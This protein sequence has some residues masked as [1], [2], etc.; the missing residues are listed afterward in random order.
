[1]DVRRLIIS[2]L[3]IL[4][5]SSAAK[6]EELSQCLGSITTHEHR[7]EKEEAIRL[8]FNKFKSVISQENCFIY[9]AKKVPRLASTK[10][11]EDIKSICFYETTSAKD[12]GSCMNNTKKFKSSSDHDEAVFYCYQQFQ[13]KIGEKECLKIAEKL[14][15][16]LKK[17]Y[18]IQHCLNN[19]F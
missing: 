11:I 1:M 5:I 14:I 8:C 2:I 3:S 9:L 15:Y 10:L 19:N 18:L 6:A 7:L 16:P 17:N 4:L 12:I 13:E